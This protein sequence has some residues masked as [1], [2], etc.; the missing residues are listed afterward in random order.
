MEFPEEN[1]KFSGSF[2]YG[3]LFWMC[4]FERALTPDLQLAVKT[5]KILNF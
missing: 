4:H 2:S 5:G 3:T 1:N